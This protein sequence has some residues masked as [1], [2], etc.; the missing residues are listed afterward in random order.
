M[1]HIAADCLSE[2]FEFGARAFRD[3]FNATIRQVTHKAVNFK[4]GGDSF[5]HVT[6]T[7]AL[8]MAGIKNLQAATVHVRGRMKPESA[9]GSNVLIKVAF[10]FFL[11]F[12][13]LCLTVSGISV[14]E[15]GLPRTKCSKLRRFLVL[16]CNSEGQC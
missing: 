9:A 3:Q 14:I 12:Y 8:H 4:S 10:K 15:H 7:N 6:K 2:C 13:V 1:F 16:V 11:H 5:H